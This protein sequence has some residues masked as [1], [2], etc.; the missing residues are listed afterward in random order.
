[1]LADAGFADVE[2]DAVGGVP[3]LRR[4]LHVVAR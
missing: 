1:V 2:V 4:A 3:L